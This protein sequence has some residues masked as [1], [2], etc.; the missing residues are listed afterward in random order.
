MHTY[1]RHIWTKTC[2]RAL[3]GHEW[4]VSFF[5]PI[6]KADYDDWVLMRQAQW[7]WTDEQLKEL[8]QLDQFGKVQDA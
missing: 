8:K 7:L 5:E 1:W 3:S 4:N 6:T 2:H